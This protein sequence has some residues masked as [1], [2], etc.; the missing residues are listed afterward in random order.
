MLTL[1]NYPALFWPTAVFAILIIG[2]SKAGLGGGLGAIATPLLALVIPV[3]DAA[4]LLLPILIIADLFSMR[5]YWGQVDGDSL[6]VLLPS[7]LVGVALGALFF[8]YFRDNEQLLKTGIG[9]IGLLFVLFQL[10]RAL[11]M[12]SLESKRPLTP[13]GLLLGT[14]AGFT[15]T[16]AHVG[17]PP[18]AIYLLPQK[19]PRHLFVG[20]TVGF[21]MVINLAKLIPYALLGLLRVGN[22]STTLLLLPLTFVGVQL[23]AWLN[24]RLNENLF[25]I[26]VY[27]LLGLTSLEL[28]FG[29]NI[30]EL[31]F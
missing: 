18:V 31:F 25:N 13:L 24:G 8:N 26:I 1:P 23:G 15:S 28:I 11:I 5:H 17:G 12:R 6:Q 22:I 20:T 21:F 14:A 7:G 2:I 3:A 30:V 29:F 4:A 10:S 19:L 9:V 16:L 27:T